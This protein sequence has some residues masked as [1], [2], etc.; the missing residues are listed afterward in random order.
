MGNFFK[1]IFGN[2]ERPMPP[3]GPIGGPAGGSADTGPRTI[4]IVIVGNSTVGKTCMITN[5]NTN[6]FNDDHVPNVLDVFRGPREI[7]GREV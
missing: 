3:P 2:N 6:A 5:Y 1:R 4:K 7:D